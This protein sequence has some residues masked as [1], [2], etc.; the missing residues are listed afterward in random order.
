VNNQHLRTALPASDA[1]IESRLAARLAAALTVSAQTLPHD[2]SERLRFAREQAISRARAQQR[3]T[4]V[5]VQLE[6]ERVGKNI[7]DVTTCYNRAY[8]RPALSVVLGVIAGVAADADSRAIIMESINRY[9]RDTPTL[10][11]CERLAMERDIDPTP[12]IRNPPSKAGNEE[13]K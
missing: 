4:A 6:A 1:S 2:V 13:D 12:Y 5:E 8:G 9:N 11:A 10:A 7:A 3:V